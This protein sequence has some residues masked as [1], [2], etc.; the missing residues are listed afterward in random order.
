MNLVKLLVKATVAMLVVAGP[1]FVGAPT[2]ASGRRTEAN[3]FHRKKYLSEIVAQELRRM[4]KWKHPRPPQT[5][6][7]PEFIQ[8]MLN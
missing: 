1:I 7:P 8:T 4:I 3:Y 5:A 2:L 6:P